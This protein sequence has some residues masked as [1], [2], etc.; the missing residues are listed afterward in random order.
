MEFAQADDQCKLTDEY[1]SERRELAKQF[2]E[3]TNECKYSVSQSNYWYTTW[4]CLE[5][6]KGSIEKEKHCLINAAHKANQ[7]K[8]TI[9]SEDMCSAFERDSD[10]FKRA[11]DEEVKRKG[12]R[13][14][15]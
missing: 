14:C 3:N 5:M 10:F 9:L 15:S 12:I 2:R 13:K 1:K 6:A 11:L 7:Y 8:K 4:Q